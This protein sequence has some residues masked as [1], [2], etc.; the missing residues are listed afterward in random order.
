MAGKDGKLCTIEDIAKE[1]G[2]SKTTVSRALSGKGRIGKETAERIQRLANERGYR[3]NA[4]ARGLAQNKTYNLGIVF[5]FDYP[6]IPF[7]KECMDGICEE[8]YQYDYDII[9][10]V[11]WKDSLSQIK[12]LVMKHKVDGM[13][14]TRAVVNS[15]T[16]KFLKEWDVPFVVIGPPGDRGTVSVDNPNREACRELTGILLLK[17]LRTLALV[18]GS[19][20]YYVTES[21]KQGFVDA[22]Q[23]QGLLADERLMFMEVDDYRKA[24][25]AVEQ[26]LSAGVDGFV[27]MDDVICTMVLGCLREKGVKVPGTVMLVSLYDSHQVEYNFPSVTSLRFETKKLG[28]Y[29]CMEMLKMLGENVREERLP[30]TYQIICRESTK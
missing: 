24:R 30:L 3:P 15:E 22:Y 8:A 6:D 12:R 10:S 13:I 14:L 28:M 26:A 27:C 29:A 4:A 21:R 23:K 2:V 5:P 17:G 7:F 16:E 19:S 1:L 11:M 20:L 9:V 18:G 25:W